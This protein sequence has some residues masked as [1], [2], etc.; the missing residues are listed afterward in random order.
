M[1]RTAENIFFRGEGFTH[2]N[3]SRRAR[4]ITEM[5]KGVVGNYLHIYGISGEKPTTVPPDQRP[6][7]ELAHLNWRL[8]RHGYKALE[9]QQWRQVVDQVGRVPSRRKQFDVLEE[10]GFLNKPKSALDQTVTIS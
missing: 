4:L 3:R 2:L 5:G 9:P 6:L 10:K 7:I 1:R 8:F